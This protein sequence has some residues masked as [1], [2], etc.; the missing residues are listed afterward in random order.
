MAKTVAAATLGCKVNMYDTESIL[1]RFREA[2]YAVRDFNDAADVYIVNTCTVTAVSDK[3]SRQM[4]R[5]SAGRGG[6]VVV[7]GCFAQSKADEALAIPGVSIV[8]GIKERGRIVELVETFLREGGIRC[9][10]T[11]Y[12]RD[13]K[14]DN[15]PV[16]GL[17]IG[18]GGRTRPVVKIQ[19]GCDNFCSYC[20]IPMARGAARSRRIEDIA[21]EVRGLAAAGAREVVLSGISAA[22]YGV[23]TGQKL[24]DVLYAVAGVADIAGISRIRLSSIG[25]AAVTP[26]FIKA[27]EQIPAICDHVHLSLQ[28]GCDTTLRRMNRKYTCAEY[29][30]A[31][32]AIRAARPGVAITTDIIAGF[33]G[34][35]DA[36]FV[37]S[38]NFAAEMGF[39][40]MHVFP[41]SRREGTEA[42]TMPDQIPTKIRKERARRMIALGDEL[43]RRFVRGNLGRVVPVLFE[44]VVNGA[45]AGLTP[46]YIEVL[47]ESAE[48]LRGRI[49]DVLLSELRNDHVTG[50]LRP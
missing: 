42:A 19:D 40:D 50:I 47:V 11:G 48:D 44:S 7:T 3:K 35:S 25:P 24:T 20:V 43:R 45:Y 26:D 46:N 30:A 8:A 23:D 27:L 31:A 33:P 38:L 9:E 18:A 36:D 10:V 29:A 5:R 14:F 21:D 39:A 1:V 6:V 2:G 4:V 16:S 32:A 15:M 28:S 49:F 17:I 12:N 22:A 37:E 41:F 34:E 13:N